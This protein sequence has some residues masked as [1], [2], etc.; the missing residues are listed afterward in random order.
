MRPTHEL[1]YDGKTGQVYKIWIV[2]ILL[3]IVTLGIY[4]FWGKTRM[5]RYMTAGM[6]LA[7]DRFEYT[8]TGG[9]LF[10]GFIKA[11]FF[12]LF[13][14]IPF[15]WSVFEINKIAE[16]KAQTLQNLQPAPSTPAN[17]DAPTEPFAGTANEVMTQA[18]LLAQNEPNQEM[19]SNTFRIQIENEDSASEIQLNQISPEQLAALKDFTP[20][21][22][23]VFVVYFGYIIFYVMFLPFIAIFQAVKYRASRLRYRGIRGHLIGSS[24]KY[25]L[26][27][28][29]HTVLVFVTVG[30]WKPFADLKLHKYKANRLYFGSQVAA[31]HPPYLRVF[32]NYFLWYA[33]I[34]IGAVMLGISE[35]GAMLGLNVG[36]GLTALFAILGFILFFVGMFGFAFGYRACLNRVKY[37]HLQFGD[38]G[39]G[40]TVTG[41]KLFKFFFVNMLIIVFTLG[42]G[43]PIVMQRYQR[44]L[45]QNIHITGDF[46]NSKILQAA[47]KEDSSGEGLLSFFDLKIKLF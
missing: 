30:L 19:E 18:T 47:G 14:S 38:I 21:Q 12:L 20:Y 26:M 44:F 8:G 2:T 27:G 4:R 7:G 41:W 15:F 29:L 28:F 16:Q 37:Q 6:M 9:E 13:I 25:G 32:M 11:L 24:L 40:C 35:I 43:F 46:E 1:Q 5:R 36:E 10:K 39:F 34:L 33:M 22:L 17:P 3:S 23:T 31:F 42:L 45:C